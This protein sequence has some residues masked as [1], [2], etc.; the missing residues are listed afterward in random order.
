MAGCMLQLL[1]SQEIGGG[2]AFGGKVDQRGWKN[3]R[4]GR[5]RGAGNF[6]EQLGVSNCRQKEGLVDRL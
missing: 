1:F 3:G 6:E 5:M 2:G 4:G